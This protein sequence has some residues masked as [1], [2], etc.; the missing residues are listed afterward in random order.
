[1]SSLQEQLAAAAY[2]EVCPDGICRR[3]IGLAEVERLASENAAPVNLV[4]Q[5]CLQAEIIPSRYLRNLGTLGYEGQ[6]RLLRS[7]VAVI[8]LGGLG[9]LITELL[10]RMGIGRLVLAD[11]D[12]FSED[13]LNRQVLSSE[14]TLRK[15]KAEVAEARVRELN[16]G[17][18][19]IGVAERLATPAMAKLLT[20]VDVAIDALDSIQSRYDLQAACA[21]VAVPMVHGAIAGHVGQVMTIFPGDAGLDALYGEAR[22][23][24][25]EAATGNPAT[26]PALVAA[27]E[28]QEAIKILTGTGEPLRNGFLFLDI[29]HNVYEFISIV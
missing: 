26:T 27:L 2:E 13:N 7:R 29:E 11:G 17:V 24:G 19:A 15:R 20:G 22:G 8:G 9:G 12:V 10:A 14:L 4:E 3:V 1:M 21:E 28:V 18:D 16:S 25:L 23:K 6:L 5:H